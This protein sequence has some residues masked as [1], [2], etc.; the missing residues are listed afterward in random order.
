MDTRPVSCKHTTSCVLAASGCD[1][2]CAACLSAYL[3]EVQVCVGQLEHQALQLVAE[4]CSLGRIQASPRHC[5][6]AACDEAVQRHQGL[7]KVPHKHNMLQTHSNS[8]RCGRQAFLAETVAPQMLQARPLPGQQQV[9]QPEVGQHP[10]Q[11]AG[12]TSPPWS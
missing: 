4:G 8:R 1:S 2:V 12:I 3:L 10:S 9:W 7:V 6:I 5:C 11:A